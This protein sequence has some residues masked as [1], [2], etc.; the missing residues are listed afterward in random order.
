[1]ALS[2]SFAHTLDAN[3]ASIA[4]LET[5][6]GVGP[7]TAQ[8]IVSE[9]ERGGHFDSLDDLSDRVRGIGKKRLARLRDAGLYVGRERVSPFNAGTIAT[10]HFAPALPA[11]TP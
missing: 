4:Q 2:N 5:L 8:L 3:V 1:V 9:R 7:R 11:L 10:P 6:N